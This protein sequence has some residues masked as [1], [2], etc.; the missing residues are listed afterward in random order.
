MEKFN[1]YRN[2]CDVGIEPNHGILEGCALKSQMIVLLSPIFFW[3][4][5]VTEKSKYEPVND[6]TVAALPPI[7]FLRIKESRSVS[8]CALAM[9]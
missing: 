7:T 9:D 6:V 1:Y 3:V 8:Y 2:I 4:L 5:P